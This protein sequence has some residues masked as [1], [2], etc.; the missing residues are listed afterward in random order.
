MLIDCLKSVFEEYP[1]DSARSVAA[2]LATY[3]IWTFVLNSR[4]P[5]SRGIRN[6]GMSIEVA[7]EDRAGRGNLIELIPSQMLTIRKLG[8]VV[9]NRVKPTV[10]VFVVPLLHQVENFLSRLTLA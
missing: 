5:E 7:Q 9:L 8:L 6:S 10:R 1:I 4:H 3:G 2:K